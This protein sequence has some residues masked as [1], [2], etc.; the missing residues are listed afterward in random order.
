VKHPLV[1]VHGLGGY[2]GVWRM[3]MPVFPE[4]VYVTLPGHP[5]GSPLATLPEMAD[6]LHGH[7]HWRGLERFVLCGHSMG[8]ALSLLYAAT[9]PQDLAGLV[10]VG[11]TARLSA[12]IAMPNGISAF[13]NDIQGYAQRLEDS[14]K[15]LVPLERVPLIR[16]M[17]KVGTHGRLADILAVSKLDI[18]DKV[19]LIKAPTLVI[20]GE[21]DG[22]MARFEALAAAIPG[23]RLY[24][25]KEAGHYAMLDQP[26]DFN[27]ALG[28]FVQGLD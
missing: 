11:G 27:R 4:A 5:E 9:W 23:A 20:A 16:D 3:Q 15:R 25:I 6:W 17:L 10:A 14:F 22:S 19:P 28:D 24:I 7:L 26:A 2:A 12:P 13:V 18:T 21:E 8:S 1:F